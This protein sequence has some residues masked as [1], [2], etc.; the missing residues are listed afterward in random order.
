MMVRP[1][2]SAM[3]IARLVVAPRETITRYAGHRAL[4][5][6]LR[7]YSASAGHIR[8]AEVNFFGK[9]MADG[10][11]QGVVSA[12]VL[13]DAD[14]SFFVKEAYAMNPTRGHMSL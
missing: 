13:D 2:L 14:C 3:E 7:R 5:R 4:Q 9:T 11:V 8:P 1:V 6:H 10:L 12:D